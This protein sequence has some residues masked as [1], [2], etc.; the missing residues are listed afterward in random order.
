M[1]DVSPNVLTQFEKPLDRLNYF[2]GQRLEAADLKLEQQ[3]HIRVRRWLNKSLY[4]TG[5]ARGLEVAQ[6][7]L[8]SLN[9]IVNQGLALDFEGREILLLDQVS[10]SVIGKPRSAPGVPDGTYLTIQYNEQV[11]EEMQDGC[12]VQA[13]KTKGCG[14]GSGNGKSRLAWGGPALVRATPILGFTD[15]LP[16]DT[17]GKI[18]LAQIELD[19]S[20][21][22]VSVH[23]EVRRYV[24]AASSAK[25][26][27][28]ALEG[29]REITSGDGVN[30]ST[31]NYT[32]IY[33]HIRGREP[34]AVTLY[35]RADTFSTL[36]YTEMG[37]HKHDSS[38]NTAGATEGPS[39]IDSHSHTLSQVQTTGESGAARHTHDTLN[40]DYWP[41]VGNDVFNNQVNV[42]KIA[43]GN[44]HGNL[45]T[46]INPAHDGTAIIEGASDHTHNLTGPGGAAAQTDSVAIPQGVPSHTH[47]IGVSSL[48]NAYAGANDGADPK[49]AASPPYTARNGAPLTYVNDLQIFIDGSPQTDNILTQ[50]TDS[51]QAGYVWSQLGNGSANHPLVARGT[52][53]IKL[54]LL[55]VL[56][57]F[58]GEHWIE[59]H[60]KTGIDPP[61]GAVIPTGG[62][63]LYNLYL[64]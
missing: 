23:P 31:E 27:Q 48:S 8:N 53:P 26:F 15:S 54:D 33:F 61:T 57:F 2:N 13:G 30:L 58:E 9:V 12:V 29:E 40:C 4:T 37:R 32:V 24:G 3:Y 62:R 46:I 43:G 16:S 19:N 52:G 42:S 17:S 51:D 39:G 47:P 49:G 38:L 44:S 64:E 50:L 34:N 7:P 21:N 59:I 35:L 18:V 22:V 28:Y 10:I 5:I 63:I 1:T 56:K 14:C 11:T 60:S 55:P 20:C 41:A 36:H 25:V 6:D 45:L